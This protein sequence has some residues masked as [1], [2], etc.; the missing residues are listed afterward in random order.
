MEINKKRLHFHALPIA[1]VLFLLIV[2]SA[3][4]ATPQ[5]A[6]AR[7]ALLNRATHLKPSSNGLA[8]IDTN[9]RQRDNSII[10]AGQTASTELILQ[11]EA[12]SR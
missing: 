4:I 10:S 12:Q 11:S 5:L 6:V 8:H 9:A 3:L 7:D 2:F 1:G